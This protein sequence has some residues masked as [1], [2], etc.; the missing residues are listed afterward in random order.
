MY[1]VYHPDHEVDAWNVYIGALIVLWSCVLVVIF[2]N[3]LVP[4]TQHVGTFFVV[5]GGIVTIIV[6]AAMP[7]QHASNHFVWNSFKENNFTG[8][9]AGVAF[10]TVCKL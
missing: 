1:T 7:K 9:P 6:L 10:L 2:G 4:Y 5:V 8:W 3:R